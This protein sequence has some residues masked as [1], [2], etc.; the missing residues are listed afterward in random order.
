MRGVQCD[1][2][3]PMTD[4]E[5]GPKGLSAHSDQERILEETLHKFVRFHWE[6]FVNLAK[7]EYSQ[8]KYS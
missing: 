8:D 1:D 4:S 7:A 3:G 6:I 2:T 5:D